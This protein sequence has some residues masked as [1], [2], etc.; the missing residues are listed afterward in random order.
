MPLFLSGVIIY[1]RDA[2]REQQSVLTRR[3]DDEAI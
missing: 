2:E 3:E 1:D